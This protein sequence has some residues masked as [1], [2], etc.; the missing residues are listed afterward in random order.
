MALKDVPTGELETIN[1]I[2]LT[3]WDERV[4]MVSDEAAT[5]CV[6]EDGL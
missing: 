4:R 3:P 2:T 6:A 5:T 1:P